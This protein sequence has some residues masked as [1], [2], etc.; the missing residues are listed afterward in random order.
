[1]T[2]CR[3]FFVELDFFLAVIT[4]L[5]VSIRN[6][7]GD[8]GIVSSVR[9]FFCFSS[10]AAAE[11]SEVQA[12]RGPFVLVFVDEGSQVVEGSEVTCSSVRYGNIEQSHFLT[13]N[14]QRK[15]TFFKESR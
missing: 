14:T 9:H 8:R 13:E 7:D 5:G 6:F 12:K 11:R 2:K 3:I 15:N 1:M 10:L 4:P